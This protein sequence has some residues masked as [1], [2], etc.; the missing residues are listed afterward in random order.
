MESD[1]KLNQELSKLMR[2][3]AFKLGDE[4]GALEIGKSA[5]ARAAFKLLHGIIGPCRDFASAVLEDS[6]IKL[7]EEKKDALAGIGDALAQM[8]DAV[9]SILADSEM[10]KADA[11]RM[12]AGYCKLLQADK[13]TGDL[14]SATVAAGFIDLAMASPAARA[15]VERAEPGT[16][17]A[18]REGLV[19]CV[20]GSLFTGVE[21]FSLRS[22]ERKADPGKEGAN[23]DPI[24]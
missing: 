23:D 9:R 19:S 1:E 18:Q 16:T 20:L 22:D 12:I 6:Q 15:C 21:G 3:Q 24:H 11:E 4:E 14:Q 13:Q 8:D 2:D 5:M 7:H 17:A 10:A